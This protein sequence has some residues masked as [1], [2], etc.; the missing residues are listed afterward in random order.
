MEASKRWASEALCRLLEG[1]DEEDSAEA[2]E[3]IPTG[4]PVM[5]L[6]DEALR[7]AMPGVQ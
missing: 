1:D 7:A 5:V 6:L 2:E 3:V 4:V